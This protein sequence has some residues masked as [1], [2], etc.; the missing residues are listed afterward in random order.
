MTGHANQNI[1]AAADGHSVF[2]PSAAHR[3]LACPGSLL[4]HLEMPDTSGVDAKIG[5]VA[6]FVAS[7]WLTKGKPHHLLGTFIN[8]EGLGV[9]VDEEMMDYVEQYVAWCGSLEGDHRVEQRV[10]FSHLTPLDNQTGTADHFAMAPGKLIMSDLKYG[11]GVKVF[12][13][14]NPQLMIYALAIIEEWDWAYGFEEITLRIC[15]PRLGAFDSWTVSRIDLEVFGL[16]VSE[17]TR[18]ALEADAP[19]VA[20]PKQCTFCKLKPTCPAAADLLAQLA[21]DSFE[22]VRPTTPAIAQQ[23]LL[24]IEDRRAIPATLPSVQAMTTSHIEQVYGYRKMVESW[25][26]EMQAELE[27]REVAGEVLTLYRIV[28][29]RSRR[30]FP[31]YAAFEQWLLQHT[32]APG[33]KVVEWSPAEAEKLLVK[34]GMKLKDAKAEVAKYT[35]KPPGKPTLA[36]IKDDRPDVDDV[37]DGTFEDVSGE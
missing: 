27:K 34:A 1:P 21:D 6:H 36:P 37:I 33:R 14:D 10:D 23:V 26:H 11:R 3:W 35:M 5:T 17:T 30:M 4:P 25:F 28:E 24:D 13:E 15:Q 22:E 18:W 16:R 31:D 8:Q 7:E 29:G 12:A 32:K 9:L 20:G 2:S 19:R